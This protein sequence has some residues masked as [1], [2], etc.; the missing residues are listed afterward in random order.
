MTRWQRLA[1]F[2]AVAAPPALTL[3]LIAVHGVNVPQWDQWAMP[4]LFKAFDLGTLDFAD[5][6]AQRNEHRPVVP[7]AIDFGLAQ[8]TAWD[9]R[10]ELFFDF[11]VALVTFALLVV[12][13]RRTLDRDG[14]VL[15]E[16]AWMFVLESLDHALA[17]RDVGVDGRAVAEEG[18]G[19]LRHR[20]LHG[21]GRQDHEHRGETGREHSGT[22][23]H[24]ADGPAGR[25]TP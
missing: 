9:I 21:V 7:Q 12:L 15:G 24:A 16:G 23:G 19:E 18:G 14:F 11:A 25:R 13:L 6:W 17:L 20:V 2:A 10:V 4:S 22:L 3:A 5:F 8:L 1:W